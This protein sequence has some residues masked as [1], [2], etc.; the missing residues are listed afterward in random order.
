VTALMGKKTP[1]AESRGGKKMVRGKDR[2][3]DPSVI[4]TSERKKKKKWDYNEE[5]QVG[6]PPERGKKKEDGAK[7]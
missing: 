2:K 4:R 7:K 1:L 5:G 3:K 6:G